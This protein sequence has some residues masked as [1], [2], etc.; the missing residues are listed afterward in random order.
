M[1]F[2][3]FEVWVWDN[4]E[5]IIENLKENKEAWCKYEDVCVIV[6]HNTEENREAMVK[7][8]K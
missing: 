3:A 2:I 1:A 5:E 8:I 6:W 7:M 4:L